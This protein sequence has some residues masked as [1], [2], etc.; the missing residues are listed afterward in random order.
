MRIR[1]K[2]DFLSG[3][4]TQ[5]VLSFLVDHPNEELLCSEIQSGTRLSKAGTYRAL[6]VLVRKGMTERLKRGRFALYRIVENDCFVKQFKV[7]KT[8]F[9]LR[10]FLKKLREASREVI[11]YG[12][13]SR[14]EDYL[15]S[16]IDVFIVA[17]DPLQIET[18]LL[19]FKL[20]RRL[21]SVIKTITEV[22]DME[23]SN[24]EFMAE[25]NSGIVLWREKDD[26]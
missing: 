13:A 18:L 12:S 7:L 2:E 20:K 9:F 24:P 8:V 4:N 21:Q 16:D 22:S 23:E 1:I 3:T 19:N 11:L 10:P 26:S 25:V 17:K 14:G 6:D 5:K 15:D